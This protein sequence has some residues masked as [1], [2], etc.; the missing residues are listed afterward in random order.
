MYEQ[1][2]T[3]EISGIPLLIK[4]VTGDKSGDPGEQT[5]RIVLVPRIL[6]HLSLPPSLPLYLLLL[7]FADRVSELGFYGKKM[8]ANLSFTKFYGHDEFGV[9]I[10]IREF[11]GLENGGKRRERSGAEEKRKTIGQK[12]FFE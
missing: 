9:D 3:A 12:G 7:V 5:C 6:L 1:R 8:Q 2:Q 11:K 4:W 10:E